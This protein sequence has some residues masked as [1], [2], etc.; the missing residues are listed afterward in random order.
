MNQLGR[1]GIVPHPVARLIAPRAA[2]V[3]ACPRYSVQSGGSHRILTKDGC[4]AREDICEGG[5]REELL[6]GGRRG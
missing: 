6:S 4:A 3:I 1:V 2:A 5:V